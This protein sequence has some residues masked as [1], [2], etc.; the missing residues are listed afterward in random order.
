M[1]M[2][3]GGS[4]KGLGLGTPGGVTGSG[5]NPVVYVEQ[6]SEAV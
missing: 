3:Y 1:G 5:T 2:V 6:V 4:S